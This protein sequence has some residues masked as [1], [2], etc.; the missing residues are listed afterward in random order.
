[1]VK[2]KKIGLYGIVA[3]ILIQ[4]AYAL[5]TG[6][7]VDVQGSIHKGCVSVESGSTA[8]NVLKA[9]DNKNDN[10]AMTIDGELTGM[11]FLRA[12][13]G[14]EGG[15]E[16][17]DPDPFCLIFSGWNFWVSDNDAS[18]TEPPELS[19]GWGMGI[20]DYII[21]KENEVIGANFAITQ[22]NPDWTILVGPQK[23]AYVR[24]SDLCEKL[25]IKDLKA[26]VDGDKASADED[27]GR[28]NDAKP[29]SEIKLE[30]EV[31]NL[32]TRSEGVDIND[33]FV[34]AI[35]EDL[36]NGD[37]LEDESD[38]YDID[39]GEEEDIELIFRIPLNAEDGTYDMTLEFVGEDYSGLQYKKTIEFKVEVEKEDHELR[40][41]DAEISPNSIKCDRTLR[42][43]FRI[44]NTGTHDEDVKLKIGNEQLG[45]N[46]EESFKL[47]EDPD[48]SDNS[49]EN[50]YYIKIDEDVA[51]GSYPI[52]I[53]AEYGDEEVSE[54]INLNI[55]DCRTSIVELRYQNLP[56]G[57]ASTTQSSQNQ[58]TMEEPKAIKPNKTL[59]TILLVN[60][61]IVVI[62]IVVFLV[63]KS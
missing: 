19:P 24:Y 7:V 13:N 3:L 28:I 52:L 29:G 18:F 11:Y 30:V 50:D 5:N 8:Y 57:Q 34:T 27:G 16:D 12:I 41:L 38:D 10:I 39:A 55:E 40:I 17:P 59:T 63:V 37:D 53:S 21:T 25:R 42:L 58:I 43:G 6:V 1:V 22:F 23:P 49:Y 44:I 36:D 33:V 9:F 62:G 46:M 20:G 51:A 60:M 54:I 35:I 48:D 4:T 31:S 61:I 47:S 15:C 56:A 14:I 26:Y 32:Y 2:I 45:V